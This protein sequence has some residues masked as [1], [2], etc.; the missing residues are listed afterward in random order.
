MRLHAWD[1]APLQA[2]T[3]RGGAR[4]ALKAVGVAAGSGRWGGG[5][6]AAEAARRPI[7]TTCAYGISRE[8]LNFLTPLSGP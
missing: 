5:Y 8:T 6:A 2:D 7:R 3:A 4:H 1:G